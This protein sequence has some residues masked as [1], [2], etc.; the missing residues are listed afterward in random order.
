MMGH[1][2]RWNWQSQ[3]VGKCEQA[4]NGSLFTQQFCAAGI[5]KL[6]LSQN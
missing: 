3:K 5:T 6:L 2:R 1:T 4:I